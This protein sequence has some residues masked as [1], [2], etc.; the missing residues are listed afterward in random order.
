MNVTTA[1]IF[2]TLLAAATCVFAESPQPASPA[3]AYTVAAYYFG[4]YHGDP[5]NEKNKGKGWSEWELV[6]AARPRGHHQPKCRSGDT[7]TNRTP[8]YGTE[9]RRGP[10]HGI[11]AFIFDGTTP[12]TAPIFEPR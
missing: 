10:D 3:D 4:N 2:T 9:D 6:K 11:D 1:A 7:P 12:M 5:R 8:R